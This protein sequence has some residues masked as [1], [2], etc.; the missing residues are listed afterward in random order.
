LSSINPKNALMSPVAA[1]L[2][3]GARAIEPPPVPPPGSLMGHQH[4][5]AE[6]DGL[7]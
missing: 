4:R 2:Y 5:M 6:R 7:P 1:H 3:V